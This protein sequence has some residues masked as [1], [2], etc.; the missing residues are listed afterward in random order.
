VAPRF[1]KSAIVLLAFLGFLLVGSCTLHI[2]GPPPGAPPAPPE[3]PQQPD[4]GAPEGLR[5]IRN[6][7][8]VRLG[9]GV[10]SSPG[11]I[12]AN[13]VEIRGSGPGQTVIEGD[14]QVRGN[15]LV[16]TGVTVRGS[17]TFLAN[18]ADF[19]GARITGSVANGGNNNVW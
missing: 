14:L 9:P 12:T 13:S 4:R 16:V 11:S 1:R 19:R 10:Y 15:N 18:N 6:N 2:G 8:D 7:A 3:G 17:V 5:G